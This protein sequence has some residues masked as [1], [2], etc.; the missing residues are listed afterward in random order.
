VEIKKGLYALER[1][2]FPEELLDL[3]ADPEGENEAELVG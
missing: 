2:N 3:L 1:S